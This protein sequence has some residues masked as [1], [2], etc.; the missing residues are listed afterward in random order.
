VC[1]RACVCVCVYAL[2]RVF[3][4]APNRVRP[5]MR[6]D[7]WLVCV[8]VCVCL[9]LCLCLW[10]CSCMCF[11][12]HAPLPQL[13]LHAARLRSPLPGRC[14][15]G[16]V[17]A[18]SRCCHGGTLLAAV[19]R[20][21]QDQVLP[22]HICAGTALLPATSAPGP[23]GPTPPDPHQSCAHSGRRAAASAPGPTGACGRCACSDVGLTPLPQL[24]RQ[25]PRARLAHSRAVGRDRAHRFAANWAHPS[26][27][28]A[29]TAR[30]RHV[31]SRIAPCCAFLPH[32]RWLGSVQPPLPSG[33]GLSG[34][35]LCGSGLASPRWNSLRFTLLS[36]T[37]LSGTGLSGTGP[38]WNSLRLGRF[39]RTF[40]R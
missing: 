31:V 11:Y 25:R 27:I 32:L 37:G 34:I 1:V 10:L 17:T 4:P 39:R 33:S 15:H 21:R 6:S 35:R 12:A 2:P 7:L 8:H 18:D 30:A 20:R 13:Q 40:R 26:H 36:G 38:H 5:S 16:G 3:T 23:N 29:G 22:G 24:R 9:C 19:P 28:C 14:C